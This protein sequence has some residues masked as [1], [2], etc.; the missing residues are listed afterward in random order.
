MIEEVTDELPPVAGVPEEERA[1]NF[2]STRMQ[3]VE[4]SARMQPTPWLTLAGNYTY[5]NF[6]TPTGTLVNRPRHRG[7]AT[8][9]GHWDDVFASGDRATAT[10]LVYLVGRRD[11]PNPFNEEEP[12]TPSSLSGYGRVDVALAYHFSGPLSG[13]AVTATARNLFNRDY[14]E[15]IGF[16]APGANFLAGLRY[17]LRPA[18]LM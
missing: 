10:T 7:A 9:A 8:A 3:G 12:F 14:S 18:S 1:E 6:V 2:S 4:L 13:L 15:S 16:P 17:D 5:L 11:S